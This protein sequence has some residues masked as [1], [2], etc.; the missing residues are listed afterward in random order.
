VTVRCLWYGVFGRQ[1]VQVVLVRDKA[2]SGYDIA[3]AT[4]DL[5]ASPGGLV[6]RYSQRL[7]IE[8]SIEDAQQPAASARPATACSLPSSE[9]RPSLSSSTP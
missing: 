6:E 2:N 1:E 5:D 9:P 8:V 3:L 7:S 4:T